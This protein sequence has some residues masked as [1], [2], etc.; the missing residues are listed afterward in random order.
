[1]TKK[2]LA[3]VYPKLPRTGLG[4]MLFVWANAVLFAEINN[5]PVVAPNWDASMFRLGPYLR[6]ELYKRFYGKLFSSKNYVS[7]LNYLFANFRKDRRIYYNPSISKLELS[8]LEVADC[9]IFIF[10]KMLRYGD[11]FI[12]LK[13][14]QSFIKQKLIASIRSS[15]YEVIANNPAPEIGIHVRLSD[16]RKLKTGEDFT[17]PDSAFIRTPIHWYIN[18]I[19]TIRKVAGYDVPATIFSDGYDSELSELLK[20]PQVSRS[21]FASALSDML[22]LSRSKLLITSSGSTF[23]YWAS[24][25]GQCP[26]IWHPAYFY[27]GVFPQEIS[28]T[29]FE[30][31]FEPKLMI[32]PDLLISNIK[33]AF[34]EDR[35]L[36][37]S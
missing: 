35:N 13:E 19:S 7:R 34:I 6:G 21:P 31:G 2:S 14:Y 5:F 11:C 29:I 27:G 22:T 17:N 10:D 24:Y 25:L 33:S 20:L 28:Q 1:M 4:N 8:Q 12:D 36:T 32:V 37:K 15:V 9:Y 26:T 3:L 23:S 16:F 30:G 18:V